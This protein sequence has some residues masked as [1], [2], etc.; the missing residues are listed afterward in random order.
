[1]EN[2]QVNKAEPVLLRNFQTSVDLTGPVL[3]LQDATKPGSLWRE[4]EGCLGLMSGVS[5]LR[6]LDDLGRE[7]QPLWTSGKWGY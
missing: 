1:M 4:T 6:Q 7:T 2:S 3:N 5:G